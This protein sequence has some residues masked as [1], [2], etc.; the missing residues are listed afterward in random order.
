MFRKKN[1][2]LKNDES[3]E[4]PDESIEGPEKSIEGPEKSF[5]GP[6]EYM[7]LAVISN[8]HRRRSHGGI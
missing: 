1:K 8:F 7:E 4:G 3:I 5:E 2:I 6:D